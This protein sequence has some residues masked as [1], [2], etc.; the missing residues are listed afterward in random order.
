LVP[1]RLEFVQELVPDAAAL[2]WLVNPKSTN[3]GRNVAAL[4]AGRAV[5]HLVARDQ[6]PGAR[7]MVSRRCETQA[8]RGALPPSGA[9]VSRS[10]LT[11]EHAEGR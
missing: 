11:P 5:L 4:Q 8:K 9:C 3:A 10:A 7:A 2:A 6:V 1:K